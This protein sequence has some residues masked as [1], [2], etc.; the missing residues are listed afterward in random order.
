MEK[1]HTCI[2]CKK[3]RNQSKM[4]KVFKNSWACKDPLYYFSSM[5][6]CSEHTDIVKVK[7]I[8]EDLEKLEILTI[9]HIKN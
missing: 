6:S 9:N 3:K 4:N 5:P 7:K 2:I 1:R 8:I